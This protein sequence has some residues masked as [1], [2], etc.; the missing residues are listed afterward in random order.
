MILAAKLP[1]CRKIGSVPLIAVI[2]H[3]QI[4]LFPVHILP[5]HGGANNIATLRQM[6][7]YLQKKINSLHPL[8]AICGNVLRNNAQRPVGKWAWC[9]STEG[10]MKF[11]IKGNRPCSHPNYAVNGQLNVLC[12]Y[13]G[14]VCPG[15]IFK[16]CV[17]A[18][19]RGK[20]GSFNLMGHIRSLE[21][22]D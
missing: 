12:C 14:Q 15:V 21:R 20:K 10:V 19:W 13:V 4:R 5:V 8:Y 6:L 16:V 18:F 7:D 9:D 22:R 17:G 11:V 3:E 1:S 2:L